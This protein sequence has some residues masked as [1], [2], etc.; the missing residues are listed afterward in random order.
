MNM[1]IKILRNPIIDKFGRLNFFEVPFEGKDKPRA[2][3]V[4]VVGTN[5]EM[6]QVKAMLTKDES[7]N[8]LITQHLKEI[9]NAHKRAHKTQ[10]QINRLKKKTQAI[11]DKLP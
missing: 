2:G 3:D 10:I 8:E 6:R 7:V 1:T 9:R 5:S 11:L 4:L